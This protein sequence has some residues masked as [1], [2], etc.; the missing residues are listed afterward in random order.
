VELRRHCKPSQLNSLITHSD[1]PS[2][3]LPYNIIR[4]PVGPFYHYFIPQISYCALAPTSEPGPMW[5]KGHS[6]EDIFVEDGLTCAG[7]F[8]VEVCLT[9]CTQSGANNNDLKKNK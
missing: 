4:P 8:S 9:Y 1:H 7:S 2:F 5:T 6:F 3:P